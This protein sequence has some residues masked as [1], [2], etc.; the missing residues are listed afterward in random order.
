M[1][2][3]PGLYD[4]WSGV[5]RV[6]ELWPTGGVKALR[7]GGPANQ[8]NQSLFIG[9]PHTLGMGDFTSID[10]LHLDFTEHLS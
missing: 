4:C 9:A 7:L 6:S 5:D 3:M 10:L 2:Q 8:S 1:D